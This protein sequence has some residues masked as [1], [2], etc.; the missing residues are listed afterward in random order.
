MEEL[1]KAAWFKNAFGDLRLVS[2]GDPKCP[3]PPLETLF[4]LDEDHSVK[5]IHHRHENCQPLAG[6]TPPRKL[7]NEIVNMTN[8]EDEGSTSSSCDEGSRAAATKG[9]EVGPSPSAGDNGMAPG[10][11]GGG[12][13]SPAT[14]LHPRGGHSNKH[15]VDCVSPGAGL[16]QGAPQG[17]GILVCVHLYLEELLKINLLLTSLMSTGTTQVLFSGAG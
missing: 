4:N 3:T 17:G 1:E 13:L 6:S 2:K 7:G 15:Q 8:S 12:W 9:G 16:N 11:T 10:T 14:L 5:T